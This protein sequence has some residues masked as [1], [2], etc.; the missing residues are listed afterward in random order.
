VNA[1]IMD[2]TTFPVPSQGYIDS[3]LRDFIVPAVGGT[4]DDAFAVKTPEKVIGIDQ[5]VA[6]GVADLENALAAQ[7][8]AGQEC[9]VFGFSQSAVITM[10]EKRKLQEQLAA[11]EEVPD[12][13]FV[14]IGVG[15]RP[16]GGIAKRFEG[17]VIPF[18]D[19]TFNGAAVDDS[20]YP[21]TTYDI[22]RQYDGLADTP[23]FV[24]N[25]VADANA[26]LGIVFVHALYGEEISLDENSPKYVEGTVVQ[27]HGDTTYYWIP[28]EDL[29]LFDPLRLVGVPESAI[30]VFE[31]F[32][33]VLVEAGYDRTVPFHEP[34]PAQLIPTLD[35]ATL[36]LQLTGAVVEQ[37]SASTVGKHYRDVVSE[38]NNELNPIQAFGKVE[39]PVVDRFNDI[40]NRAGVP[41]ALNRVID[42]VLHPVTAWAE[43]KVLFPKRDNKP[44]P[45]ASVARQ[46]LKS[47]APNLGADSGDWQGP[48]KALRR[49]RSVAAPT[50]GAGPRRPSH[51]SD[52]QRSESG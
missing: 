39:G 13:T 36:S 40:V 25:P 41:A 5:S 21:I 48:T 6:D 38:L 29:P 26:V 7:C 49:D 35:P 42:P 4:Y 10:I 24:L 23:Q 34:T 32:F 18:F 50:R 9:V 37:S 3:A 14:G 47:V 45:I 20:P 27:E 19:F 15:N 1:L 46:V 22:A 12:V 2:G 33:K 31:P 8:S 17:I 11:G 44:G 51:S 16:N 43:D 28:T 52:A 30:D